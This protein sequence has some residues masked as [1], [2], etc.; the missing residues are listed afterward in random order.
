MHARPRRPPEPWRLAQIVD[1]LDQGFSG[2]PAK[3]EMA[4]QYMGQLPAA[5][6]TVLGD[7]VAGGYV[8][9]P[10]FQLPPYPS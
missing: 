4:I 2:D 3:V 5:A 8:A 9:G 10:T 7:P 1:N 6:T